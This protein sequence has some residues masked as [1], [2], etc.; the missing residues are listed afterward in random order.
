MYVCL[1]LNVC[2]IKIQVPRAH[3]VKIQLMIAKRTS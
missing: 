3:E 1:C 2:N